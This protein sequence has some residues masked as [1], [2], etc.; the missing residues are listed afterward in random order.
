MTFPTVEPNAASEA[1]F[2]A[3]ARN[4]LV[5]RRC[6]HCGH[7][8]APRRTTCRACGRGEAAWVE[9]SGTGELV[10]WGRHPGGR[11]F[12]MVELAEGPWM[13][14]ALV[15]LEADRLRSGLPVAVRFVS[16]EGGAPYPVFGPATDKELDA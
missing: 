3:A 16:G 10:T 15:G 6:A 7:T 12:G 1:F 2:D 11:L 9:A 14:T 5:L 13:E 8:R 4:V